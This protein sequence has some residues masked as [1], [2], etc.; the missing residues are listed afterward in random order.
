MH[1]ARFSVP[2][3]RPKNSQVTQYLL[4]IYCTLSDY[5]AWMRWRVYQ[6]PVLEDFEK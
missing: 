5:L 1:F 6:V 3:N 4:I 2:Y